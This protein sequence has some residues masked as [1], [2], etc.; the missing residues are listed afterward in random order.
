MSIF[1]NYDTSGL[2]YNLTESCP[3]VYKEI[4]TNDYKKETDCAGNLTKLCW[5]EKSVFN[6]TDTI[7]KNIIV[8]CD[9]RIYETTGEGPTDITRGEQ[10]QKAYN[11]VDNKCWTC[12]GFHKGKYK[13]EEIPIVENLTGELLITLQQDMTNKKVISNILNF[14]REVIYTFEYE[15]SN[16]E[17]PIDI[18]KYPLLVQGQYWLEELIVSDTETI[19]VKIIPITII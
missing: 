4:N 5:Y 11:T 14:R 1:N 9:A 8:D 3:V 6:L 17:I 2:K 15:T 10:C 16:I 18:I 19:V 12:Y 7:N 13:W